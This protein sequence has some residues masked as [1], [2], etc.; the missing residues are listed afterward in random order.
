MEASLFVLSYCVVQLTLITNN[1]K[2]VYAENNLKVR[3]R[4][5]ARNRYNQASHLTQD[6]NG[7][8]TTSLSD[9]TNEK[10]GYYQMEVSKGA[11]IR[12]SRHVLLL[13][14]KTSMRF[15]ELSVACVWLIILYCSNSASCH[16]LLFEIKLLN[17]NAY[18]PV[19]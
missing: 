4:A 3:K 2:Y 9:I 12:N 16:V 14:C 8:V 13:Y 19:Q 5:N 15:S 10:N 11:K 7:K 17:F 18:S 6:T 1:G